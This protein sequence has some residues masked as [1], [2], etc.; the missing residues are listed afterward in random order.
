MKRMTIDECDAAI[1]RWRTKFRIAINRLDDLERIK[2][3]L[4]A[5]LAKE[6][7][8]ARAAEQAPAQHHPVTMIAVAAPAVETDHLSEPA[9]EKL[10]TAKPVDDDMPDFL[11]RR[12]EGDQR[13][14]LA[15]EAILAEQTE[16]KKNKARARIETMKAK[17]AGDLKKM[18][19][20][21]KAAL[22]AIR[23]G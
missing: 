8:E 9:F 12:K 1:K 4:V 10:A 21:G 6:A 11:R 5:R 15:R 3:R 20:T 2:K 14:A 19:L 18:P 7:A 22:D 13:D 17:K 23:N 16:R